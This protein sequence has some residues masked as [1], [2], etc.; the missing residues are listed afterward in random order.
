MFV[1]IYNHD[2]DFSSYVEYIKDK[3]KCLVTEK[4][5]NYCEYMN[6]REEIYN[7]QENLQIE[8]DNLKNTIEYIKYLKENL[9]SLTSTK[10][11]L[12]NSIKTKMKKIE[13][14]RD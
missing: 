9:D 7:Q 11:N 3:I 10:E 4:Y 6:E 8:T 13:G 14:T 5:V 2:P 12:K 1:Y